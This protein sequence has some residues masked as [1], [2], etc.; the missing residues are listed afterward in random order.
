MQSSTQ[1]FCSMV[2][3]I[4]AVALFEDKK[5]ILYLF[6]GMFSF[7]GTFDC[8]G[9]VIYFGC[10]FQMSPRCASLALKHY[11]LKP[12]QRIPQYRLLLT[13]TVKLFADLRSQSSHAPDTCFQIIASI[14]KVCLSDFR[15]VRLFKYVS[16]YVKLFLK[17]GM[18]LEAFLANIDCG[19]I[20]K[21]SCNVSSTV[22]C[23]DGRFNST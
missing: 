3:N 9:I 7:A 8:C 18:G 1:K 4:V 23:S 2:L 10:L 20:H 22:V 13:G 16:Q 11:L 15:Y 12:V 17:H 14:C 21:R 6:V 19:K 5:L